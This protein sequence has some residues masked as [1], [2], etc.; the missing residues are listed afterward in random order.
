MRD[1]PIDAWLE[2][3][4]AE[5][6]LHAEA[7][8]WNQ[9][10]AVKTIYVG[11]GT[12]SLLPTGGM[13]K[14]AGRL[15][16]SIMWGPDVEWT[17]EANPETLT[18]S[19]AED[20]RRAGVNRLSL[21]AQTFHEDALRW[22]GRLHGPD[23]PGRAMAAAREAGFRNISIDL[24][25]GLPSRLGRDWRG[26][27]ERVLAMEPEH[28][29]LYGLTAEPATPLGR[30]VREGRETLAA[31]DTY[32][33]EYLTAAELLTRSGYEHYEVSN[34][35]LPGHESRH[36][37][38]YWLGAGYVGLGPGSHS[39]LPPRRFWNVRDW[40]EYRARVAAGETPIEGEETLDGAARALEG[41]WLG[42]RT[43]GG[44]SEL[45]S[46]QARLART[47]QSAGLAELEG[48]RLR[49]TPNGWLL[50]DRL[51][52]EMDAVETPVRKPQACRG[53]IA[54]SDSRPA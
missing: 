21:G 4:G 19:L 43:A 5:L 3:V 36:N 41:T 15:R 8:S 49:L 9:P 39:Y 22:M 24:I 34:F 10:F 33:T 31:E 42:L 44:L 47:W 7:G 25:F 14:L 23:G 52:V 13:A 46:R 35:A 37:R 50:L 11:G 1:P 20:W 17:A 12:P 26:D 48:G 18:A 16:E 32:E 29:S 40:A 38:A 6:C 45:S 30:W 54:T 27:L 2:A 28:V 53:G 51:A